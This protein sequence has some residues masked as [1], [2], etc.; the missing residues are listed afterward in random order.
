M[1]SP[2]V[3]LATVFV[4]ASLLPSATSTWA[5]QKFP[6]R[7]GEWTMTTPN[8]SDPKNPFVLNFCLNDQ[9]WGRAL[10][11][12]PICTIS[13]VKITAIGAS[14][15]LACNEKSLQ[16]TGTGTWA[17]D[18]MEHIAV[19]TVMM[20][21]TGGKTTPSTTTGDFRWKATACSPNDVNLR[22]HPSN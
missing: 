10:S 6:L 9:T 16:M 21:T 17:F 15:N 7:P 14:Y 20:I 22:A 8:P 18:G 5:Q 13:N 19:K 3:A 12:N 2:K 11:Q 4:F 1:N